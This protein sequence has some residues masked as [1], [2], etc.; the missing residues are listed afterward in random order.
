MGCRQGGEVTPARHSLT[1]AETYAA[2]CNE[3]NST[4]LQFWRLPLSQRIQSGSVGGGHG[5]AGKAGW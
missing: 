4:T 5:A 3:E 1:H 2:L